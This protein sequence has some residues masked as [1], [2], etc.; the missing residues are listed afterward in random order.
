MNF[1]TV[2]YTGFT[3]VVASC[4][5]HI[6]E[7]LRRV[8]PRGVQECVVLQRQARGISGFVDGSVW[9]ESAR[10][11][12]ISHKAGVHGHLFLGGILECLASL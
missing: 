12:L 9:E 7:V 2:A 10:L 11:A 8:E 5:G 4:I 3:A 1:S 6:C